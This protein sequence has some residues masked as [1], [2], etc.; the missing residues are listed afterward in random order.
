MHTVAVTF[1]TLQIVS[2]D[3]SINSSWY[4]LSFHSEK[5][6]TRFT[7]L[8]TELLAPRNDIEQIFHLVLKL[9]NDAE[10]QF[11]IRKLFWKVYSHKH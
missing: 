11:F 8:R 9:K 1:F 10:G 2:F 3:K 6:E 5:M 4:V 7:Q